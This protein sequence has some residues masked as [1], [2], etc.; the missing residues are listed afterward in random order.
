V[1][2]SAYLTRQYLVTGLAVLLVIALAAALPLV[3][4]APGWRWLAQAAMIG[5]ASAA[6]TVLRL[7]LARDL[8]G[9][10]AM[11]WSWFAAVVT[12]W[13]MLGLA[14]AALID[15]ASRQ[16]DAQRR[17]RDDR[18]AG[19]ALASQALEARL[20][21]LQAQIEPHFLFNTLANVR[22]LYEV[23]AVLGARMLGSL[24]G[25]LRAALPAMRR[26]EA[27]LA[28][29]FELVRAYLTL[30]QLRM[31]E[32][33]RFAVEFAPQ[34]AS[35]ALPP[36][37]VVTLVE[38]AIRH[39]L[40]P[41]PAG[42]TVQVRAALTAAGDQL[43]IEVRDDGAGFVAASGSGVGLA[44]TRARLAARHGSD[45]SLRLRSNQPRG[46]IAELRFAWRP[47]AVDGAAADARAAPAAPQVPAAL[48]GA[49]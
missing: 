14:A 49:R 10:I 33:L 20:A 19:D 42:G 29:E 31:G 45:A 41:L 5:A 7:A 1:Y 35:A 40:G 27:P 34:L 13:T 2:T 16:A 26:T 36:L 8:N 6:S 47:V 4:L 3:R 23:D 15:A 39:G 12:L 22:R 24:L 21:A 46:V 17:L 38:N 48:A 43:L 9:S 28:Q 44:N 11:D 37:M 25:Y 30:M 32:R 18:A